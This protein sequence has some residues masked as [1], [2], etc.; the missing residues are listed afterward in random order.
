MVRHSLLHP[1]QNM[2]KPHPGTADPVAN[3]LIDRL[4]SVKVLS[5]RWLMRRIGDN[6][7]GVTLARFGVLIVLRDRG[8]QKMSAI[9]KTVG[10]APRSVTSLVDRLERDGL[11]RRTPHP[12]DRRATMIELTEKGGNAIGNQAHP[13]ADVTDLLMKTLRPGEQELLL[14]VYE[15]WEGAIQDELRR[16]DE[17]V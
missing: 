13:F 11:A 2:K 5:E 1:V 3:A 8:P 6:D 4:N 10:I 14:S 15:R 17:A 12:T 9:S 16:L 7:E